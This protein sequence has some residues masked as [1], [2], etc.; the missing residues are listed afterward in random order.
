[1]TMYVHP[2]PPH[3][4]EQADQITPPP[5]PLY[6]YPCIIQML[7]QIRDIHCD[8]EFGYGHSTEFKFLNEII[9]MCVDGGG[10][11]GIRVSHRYLF[12]GS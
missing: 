1:M 11:G 12:K 3:I 10:G 2:P 6:N 9:A 8:T 5:S 4:M 7:Y